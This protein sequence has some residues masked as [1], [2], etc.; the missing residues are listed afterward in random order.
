MNS[1]S[2]R[3]IEEMYHAALGRELE[4]RAS[5]LAEACGGDEELRR[6]VAA[7]LA[8]DREI[9]KTEGLPG[10]GLKTGIA[11]LAR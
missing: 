1:E 2:W 3:R 11:A 5:F 9:A 10:L 4:Q 6:E 8:T 7:L